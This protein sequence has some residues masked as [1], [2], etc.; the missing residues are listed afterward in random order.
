M[1]AATTCILMCLSAL[2]A[3]L[4]APPITFAP[5]SSFALLVIDMQNTF[6]PNTTSIVPQATMI[7]EVQ[8][9]ISAFRALKHTGRA[10]V[11]YTQHGY[12]NGTSCDGHLEFR[13]YWHSR[14]E[15][16]DCDDMAVGS[17]GFEL[18]DEIQPADD[19][20]LMRKEVSRNIPCFIALIFA[21]KRCTTTCRNGQMGQ[22]PRCQ[23]KLV[24]HWAC[25]QMVGREPG[26][27]HALFLCLY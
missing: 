19:E 18:I 17:T 10:H 24:Q 22:S 9:T 12:L 7:S 1:R 21:C 27:W 13:R 3:V 20:L 15:R 2:T 6:K 23:K 11:V 16:P 8:K 26:F 14:G 4:S 25:S 5:D